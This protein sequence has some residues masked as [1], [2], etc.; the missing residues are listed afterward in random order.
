MTTDPPGSH[1]VRARCGDPAVFIERARIR[2]TVRV[3]PQ[4]KKAARRSEQRAVGSKEQGNGTGVE[5]APRSASGAVWYDGELQYRRPPFHH[6]AR[7]RHRCAVAWPPAPRAPPLLPRK[8]DDDP[9]S[10]LVDGQPTSGRE[11]WMGAIIL[12]HLG[13]RCGEKDRRTAKGA[14]PPLDGPE[15]RNGLLLAG[16]GDA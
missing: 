4:E 9:S 15:D 5:S 8:R 2:P 3:E 11:A 14:C 1:R 10:G 16:F 12:S 7:R 6:P 13:E